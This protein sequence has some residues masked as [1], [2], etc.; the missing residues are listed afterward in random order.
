MSRDV[1]SLLCRVIDT[2]GPQPRL[3]NG[4]PATSHAAAPWRD[5]LIDIHGP[6]CL[7]KP[8]PPGCSTRLLDA[9]GG[10]ETAPAQIAL[11]GLAPEPQALE[12][13]LSA[14]DGLQRE[15]ERLQWQITELDKLVAAR[16]TKWDELNA[17]Q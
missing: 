15:R 4:T 13:A 14:Q 17:Q 5:Q 7:A 2:Q 1:A 9:Y 6:A 16:R 8:D 10:I 3:I 11:A 12:Q